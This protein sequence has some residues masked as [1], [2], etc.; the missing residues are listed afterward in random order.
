MKFHEALG[1]QVEEDYMCRDIWDPGIVVIR[2]LTETGSHVYI[3]H[4]HDVSVLQ[5]TP[6]HSDLIA[7]DWRLS[8]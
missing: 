7:T 5:W 8:K 3:K 2:E 1:M 4:V 6:S